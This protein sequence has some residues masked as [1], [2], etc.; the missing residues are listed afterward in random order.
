MSVTVADCERVQTSWFQLRS[1]V[2]GVDA[3]E[4]TGLVWANGDLLF[5]QVIDPAAL[6]RGVEPLPGTGVWRSA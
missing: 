5:P 4:D 2:L 1:D 3:W 6:T